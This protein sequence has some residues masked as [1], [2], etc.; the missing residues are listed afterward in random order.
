MNACPSV[1]SL[2]AWLAGSVPD[3]ECAA[4]RRHVLD[5]PTCGTYVDEAAGDEAL[6]PQVQRLLEG[7]PSSPGPEETFGGYRLIRRLG[8]GA[9]GLVYEAEQR[10]P[11]RTV[12]LKLLWAGG[13]SPAALRRFEHEAALLGRLNHPAV[14]QVFEAGVAESPLGP[15][16][17]IALELVRGVPLTRHVEDRGLD[18]RT[19]IDLLAAV[20]DGVQHA[21]GRG[22]IHRDLKPSNILVDQAG[23][24]KIVDF[25]VARA[26]EPG[27]ETIAAERGRLIGTVHYMSPEQLAGDP[28]AVDTRSDVY[29]LGVVA[30]EALTGRLPYDVTG[31][32]FPDMVRTFVEAE[33]LRPSRSNPRLRGDLDLILL[34]ALAKDPERR[35]SSAAALG[36][37]LRRH[38][39]DEPIRARPPSAP[40]ALRKFARRHPALVIGIL[41][42]IVTVMAGSAVSLLYASRWRRAEADAQVRRLRAE[43]EA[44]IRAAVAG[45]LERLLREADPAVTPDVEPTLRQVLDRAARM[46][47]A[48]LAS[49]EPEVEIP[50]RRAVARAYLGLGA[51]QEAEGHARAAFALAQRLHGPDH[52]EVAADQAVLGQAAAGRGRH[53]E[54]VDHLRRSL[55]LAAGPGTDPVLATAVRGALG[56]SLYELG[57]F[58]EA[59]GLFRESHDAL[60]SLHGP[61]SVQAAL[62]L[63]NLGNV[64]QAKGDLSAAEHLHREVLAILVEAL[65]DGHPRAAQEEVALAGTLNLA[66]R[67]AEAERLARQALAV[68]RKRFDKG[69]PRTA[70]ALLQLGIAVRDCGR[71]AE[72]LPLLE[73][74]LAIQERAS[75]PAHLRLVEALMNVG[76][77][78]FQ[79]GDLDGSEAAVRRAVEIGDRVL[80]PTHRMAFDAHR[81]LGLVHE[82]RG[83][84]EKAVA[85]F[86]HAIE[87]ART[88]L[89]RGE[90]YRLELEADLGGALARLG[91]YGEAEELLLQSHA[92]LERAL[93]RDHAVTTRVA[94]SVAALYE[95]WGKP[96][97]AR[98]WERR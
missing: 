44:R 47:V 31:R 35:Y 34:K 89:G 25:G 76:S 91:R 79:L 12:A 10:Q 73:E 68:F 37:D 63:G 16:P 50:V 42:M 5:C 64:L 32:S 46:A 71:A 54:A 82:R 85:E 22:V 9:M 14:A 74:A 13:T 3:P 90:P 65:G 72:A 15:R 53:R 40:Y 84:P 95:Q 8:E 77:A 20:C 92:G 17:F 87:A 6:V 19:R 45:V 59:E 66:G 69:G 62:A 98:A 52:P 48:E 55:E 96:E 49:G 33:P 97:Q 23:R 67:P 2:E 24:P 1:E 36:E 86:R 39:A 41:G 30:Y 83:R 78:R 56:V 75:G 51:H 93:G 21:H 38:Q 27:R 26:V 81:G 88:V 7:T 61:R 58:E 29:S 11:P 57:E 4:I 94:G 80:G 60:R 28:E 43:R 18:L 70:S